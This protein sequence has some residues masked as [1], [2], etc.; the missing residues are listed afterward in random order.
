M[1]SVV[2]LKGEKRDPSLFGTHEVDGL[3]GSTLTANGVNA[4]LKDYLDCYKGFIEKTKN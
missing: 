4:M 2:M 3:S 1:V